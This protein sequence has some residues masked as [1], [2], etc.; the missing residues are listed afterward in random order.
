MD[1]RLPDPP[2]YRSHHPTAD[3]GPLGP[4]KVR[5][6]FRPTQLTSVPDPGLVGTLEERNS[7]PITNP[8]A[9]DPLEERTR[10]PTTDFDT[11]V[12]FRGT[13]FDLTTLAPTGVSQG[14]VLFSATYL[15]HIGTL[16]IRV[17]FLTTDLEPKDPPELVSFN[18]LGR[19]PPRPPE[20]RTRFHTADL[21]PVRPLEE[22]VRFPIVDF[23]PTGLPERIRLTFVHLGPVGP[24]E[25]RNCFHTVELGSV[26]LGPPV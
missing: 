1:L 17:R 7:H 11:L 6:C 3:P 24:T 23:A 4:T 21:G 16:K 5:F 18:I 10:V 12:L 14:R 25:G 22:R 15:D 8:R 2:L 13:R 26:V 20:E 9:T 19:G